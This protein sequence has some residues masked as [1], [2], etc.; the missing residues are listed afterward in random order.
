MRRRNV[1]TQ[2]RAG[3]VNQP[4]EK[5]LRQQCLDKGLSDHGRRNTLVARLQQHASTSSSKGNATEAVTRVEQTALETTSVPREN[6]SESA[7]P[8]DAQLA[9]INLSSRG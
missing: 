7:L 3:N 4:S 5:D 6:P 9:Q 2:Q 1:G 8:N